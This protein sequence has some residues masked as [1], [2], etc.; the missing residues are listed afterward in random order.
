VQQI[1]MRKQVVM[2]VDLVGSTELKYRTSALEVMAMVDRLLQIAREE[3]GTRPF[4]FTGD[5]AMVLADATAASARSLVQAAVLILMRLERENLTFLMPGI[6]VRIGIATGPCFPI[7]QFDVSGTIPD[8]AARLCAEADPDSILIDAATCELIGSPAADKLG[9]RPCNRRL[10]LK[11]VPMDPGAAESFYSIEPP[12]LFQ[13]RYRLER[14]E[15]GH[16]ALDRALIALYPNR[17]ALVEELSVSRMIDLAAPVNRTDPPLLIAGRTLIAW[18][19]DS[20]PQELRQ[21][22]A[23]GVSFFFVIGAAHRHLPP[24]YGGNAE[25]DPPDMI[26]HEQ[27]GDILADLRASLPVLEKLC[28]DDPTHFHLEVIAGTV[29]T[30]GVTTG[31][32]RLPNPPWRTTRPDSLKEPVFLAMYDINAAPEDHKATLVLG[33]TDS[34][35]DG[36]TDACMAHG[37]RKRVMNMVEE[38][39]NATGRQPGRQVSSAS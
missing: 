24:E 21:A 2:F 9:A 17:T 7:L 33:C 25:A 3:C 15:G 19:Q 4:K 8:L 10:A 28:T 36:S 34:N 20:I 32:F 26:D 35:G 30:D 12:R 29:I 11:G 38:A 37:L 14:P 39:R 18:T 23:R 1:A 27:D 13:R 16:S 31:R 22:A 5:G 6:H